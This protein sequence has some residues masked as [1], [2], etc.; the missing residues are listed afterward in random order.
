MV[1]NKNDN[2]IEVMKNR[3]DNNEKS[4]NEMEVL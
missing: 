4:G 1:V 3:V 2:F